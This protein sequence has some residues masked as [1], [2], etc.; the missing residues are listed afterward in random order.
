M[1]LNL[2][3]RS[4]PGLSMNELKACLPIKFAGHSEHWSAEPNQTHIM[5]GL[6]KVLSKEWNSR[7]GFRAQQHIHR[8]A[9]CTCC[10]R[11]KLHCAT[12][13]CIALLFT[14]SLH[15]HSL[16]PCT[17]I[18]W[19]IVVLFTGTLHSYSL[20]LWA[21]IWCISLHCTGEPVDGRLLKLIFQ[22]SRRGRRWE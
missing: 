3:S 6:D 7:S 14:G 16:G 2:N 5:H 9:H 21:A 12:F 11:C 4:S 13:H 10:L 22:P 17:V 20:G 18:Y 8:N 15:C 19:G 1:I